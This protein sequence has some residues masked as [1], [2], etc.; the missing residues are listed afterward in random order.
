MARRALPRLSMAVRIA[1]A[2]TLFG[3]VLIVVGLAVGYWSLSRQLDARSAA[4]MNGRRE[5][6]EHLLTEAKSIEGLQSSRHRFT[7]VLIGHDDLF[8]SLVDT[9]NGALIA[10][11]SGPA[12]EAGS[13]AGAVASA[14]S[15][16]S[17]AGRGDRIE[18]I[19]AVQQLADG[20]PVRYYLSIDRH[21]DV[22]LLNGFVR[23]SML[24]VPVLLAVVAMGAWLLARMALAPLMRF[25]RLAAAIG[26]K[27]LDQR[28]SEAD[29]PAELADLAREFNAM[30]ERIDRGYRRLQEFSAD[31]AHEMRTPIAT[32][33]GRTQVSL[34][35]QRTQAEL[36]EVLE[37]DIEELERLSRLIADMLFIAQAEHGPAAL[38]LEPLELA[39][40]AGRVTEYLS[41]VGEEKGVR[42]VVQGGARVHAERL[43]IQR[44]IT[45]LVSNAIRYARPGSSVRIVIAQGSDGTQLR[46]EN[47][48]ETIA[49]EHLERIFDRFYRVD[50]SRTRLSGGTGLGL[51]IVRSIMEAHGGKVTA[52][53]DAATATTVFTL[54]FPAQ[55]VAPTAANHRPA[56]AS[57]PPKSAASSLAAK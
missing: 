49:P 21:E 32:L 14:S 44:A 24:T 50:A 34:S 33:M 35:Q 28:V 42:V 56:S 10:T 3:L 40:E 39:E 18:A 8:L 23:A 19:Q 15:A 26:E 41:M 36:R 9:R 46:V 25:R 38:K 6:V 20:T 51:A 17:R 5:L 16:H 54:F 7:D 12:A 37:G 57:R 31:L 43:L 45:N 4:E 22:K 30:L 47:T 52:A 27:S 11:Y 2:T 48:G 1:L 29:L 53:S 55:P 13:A